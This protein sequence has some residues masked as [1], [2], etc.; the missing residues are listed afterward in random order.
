[1]RDVS[2]GI[3]ARFVALV[4]EAGRAD[5]V[6]DRTSLSFAPLAAAIREQAYREKDPRKAALL[7]RFLREYAALLEAKRHYGRAYRATTARVKPEHWER[8]L[9]GALT[10]FRTA[11]YAVELSLSFINDLDF[12]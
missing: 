9:A 3:E 2:E 6:E 7:G 11:Y 1:M 4:E 8:H 5:G 12:S 10:E